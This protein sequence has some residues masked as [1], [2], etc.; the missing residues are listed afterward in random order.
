MFNVK[1]YFQGK[2][3]QT[4]NNLHDVCVGVDFNGGVQEKT[5]Q[6]SGKTWNSYKPE[7]SAHCFGA[8]KG[9]VKI[10]TREIF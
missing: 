2:S 5:N 9:W 4:W 8:F 10:W 1:S 6:A 7:G 3:R